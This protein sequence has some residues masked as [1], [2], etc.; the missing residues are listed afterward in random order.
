[1][2]LGEGMMMEL[3]CSCR[4]RSPKRAHVNVK[5]EAT[6]TTVRSATPLG[7]NTSVPVS[8]IAE[9]GGRVVC[10]FS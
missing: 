10:A 1:V 5:E 3:R 2:W 6:T 7:N 9:R 8:V 4:A